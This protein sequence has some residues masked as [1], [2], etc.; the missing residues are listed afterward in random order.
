MFFCPVFAFAEGFYIGYQIG[1]ISRGGFIAGYQIDPKNSVELHLGGG[2]HFLTYGASLKRKFGSNYLLVGYTRVGQF[3]KT[4]TF[5][6][7]G[8]NIGIGHF[9]RSEENEMLSYPIEIGGGPGY[10]PARSELI[11][12]MFVGYG[13]IYGTNSN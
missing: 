12:N 9:F 13:V 4:E 10:D 2:P 11:P 3:S 6:N 8:L 5:S 7:H 1:V